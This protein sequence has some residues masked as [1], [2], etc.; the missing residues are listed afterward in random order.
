MTGLRYLVLSAAVAGLMAASVVRGAEKKEPKKAVGK[1]A[2]AVTTKPSVRKV[3]PVAPWHPGES[4]AKIEEALASRIQLDFTDAPL[5]DVID[6]LKDYYRIE[7]QLDRR[8]LEEVN[9]TSET[10]VTV[11][12]KGICLRSALRL[13]LRNMEPELTYVIKNE[14][15]LITTPDIAS[16]ELVTKLYDVADLVVYRDD[17]NALCDDYD[18]LIEMVTST[19]LS[20]SW[21]DVGG[22]G[23]ATGYTLGTAKV[24]AVTQTQEAHQEIDVLLAKIREIAKRNQGLGIPRRPKPSSRQMSLKAALA[25][26]SVAPTVTSVAPAPAG[27]AQAPVSPKKPAEKPGNGQRPRT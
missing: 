18:P 12:V 16:E 24:L 3:V 25:P 13:V 17:H 4:E 7:I 8:V 10:P 19:I 9:V 21:D 20:R 26:T 27:G 6:Y 11:N 15:L 14:V 1:P 2:A 22:P 5:Q 23:S